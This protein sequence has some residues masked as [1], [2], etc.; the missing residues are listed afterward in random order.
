MLNIYFLTFIHTADYWTSLSPALTHGTT[1]RS[2]SPQHRHRRVYFR[3][4]W[5]IERK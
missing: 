5:P 2:T 3:Q 4:T 1:Y